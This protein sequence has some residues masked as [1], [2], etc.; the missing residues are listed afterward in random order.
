MLQGRELYDLLKG[1]GGKPPILKMEVENCSVDEVFDEIKRGRLRIES[2]LIYYTSKARFTHLK[3]RE[4]IVKPPRSGS[5]QGEDSL[6]EI[7]LTRDD[8]DIDDELEPDFTIL[9]DTLT[10]NG[11]EAASL[12]DADE[13]LTESIELKAPYSST[14]IGPRFHPK[15]DACGF[16]DHETLKEHW[17]EYYKD[18][19]IIM[20]DRNL[21]SI[22]WVY[23]QNAVG[24]E[25][26]PY[27]GP[28]CINCQKYCDFC[29]QNTAQFLL[30]GWCDRRHQD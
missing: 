6:S 9:D 7:S 1:T 26:E 18:K 11:E 25:A 4:T 22:R 29:W 27:T 8:S 2:S 13:D 24:D 14:A 17:Y 23:D 16:E 15:C 21:N 3:T 28:T 19:D 12:P 5:E 30:E 20:D 10:S